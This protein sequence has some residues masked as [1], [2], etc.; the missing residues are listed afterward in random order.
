MN[1]LTVSSLQGNQAGAGGHAAAGMGLNQNM[2]MAAERTAAAKRT[3]ARNKFLL[4]KRKQMQQLHPQDFPAIDGKRGGMTCLQQM[5]TERQN[6]LIIEK[7]R[8][9]GRDLSSWGL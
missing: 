6:A 5:E 9:E 1:N 4:R 2:M 3:G 7:L 8:A